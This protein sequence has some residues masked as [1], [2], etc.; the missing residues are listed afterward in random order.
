M[1]HYKDLLAYQKAYQLAMKVFHI[2]KRFPPEER[3]SLTQNLQ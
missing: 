1:G 2:S 3:Y